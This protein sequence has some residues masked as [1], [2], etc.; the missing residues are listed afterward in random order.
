M[1]LRATLM[2][3]GRYDELFAVVD[4]QSD[5]GERFGEGIRRTIVGTVRRRGPIWNAYVGFWEAISRK[6]DDEGREFFT[7][8]CLQ[9]DHDFY[10][11]AAGI[12][13]DGD[14]IR[15]LL[16]EMYPHSTV[17]DYA[18]T[19]RSR[20]ARVQAYIDRWDNYQ[21]TRNDMR[22]I[23]GLNPFPDKFG[24]EVLPQASIDEL[25]KMI[26]HKTI[27]AGLSRNT[28]V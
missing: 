13:I 7:G 10:G 27:L 5:T 12:R 18:E 19:V 23:E 15:L 17:E 9:V 22:E 28:V 11:N 14:T 2:G 24:N 16:V 6:K 1:I 3:D 21:I 8:N 25:R 20:N 26:W 4:V